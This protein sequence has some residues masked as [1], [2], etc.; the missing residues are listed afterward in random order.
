MQSTCNVPR[1]SLHGAESVNANR[2][3]IPGNLLRSFASQPS[4]YSWA[5]V[6]T[7]HNPVNPV[8]MPVKKHVSH[9]P[10]SVGRKGRGLSYVKE[11]P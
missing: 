3:R 6:E 8:Y 2:D 11:V 5:A 7:S 4:L 9:L 10:T 1:D